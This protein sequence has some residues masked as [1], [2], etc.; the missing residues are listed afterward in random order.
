MP[1]ISQDEG[2]GAGNFRRMG[3]ELGSH[4]IRYGSRGGPAAKTSL[5]RATLSR[6]HEDCPAKNWI[7]VSLG[8][9]EGTPS[10]GR[11]DPVRNANLNR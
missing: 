8:G 7:G 9:L 11:D 5:M 1:V 2:Q 6:V 10:P 4:R 3:Y